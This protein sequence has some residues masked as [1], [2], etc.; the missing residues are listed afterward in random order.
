[1]KKIVLIMGVAASISLFSC[2]NSKVKESAESKEDAKQV[3]DFINKDSIPKIDSLLLKSDSL[4][5]DS[6]KADS[7]KETK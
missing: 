2:K 1:M 6:L 4:K 7:L 3:E 5:L